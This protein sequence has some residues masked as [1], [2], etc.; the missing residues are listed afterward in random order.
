[1][2][3]DGVVLGVA[4]VTTTIVEGE[5]VVVK[6]ALVNVVLVLDDKLEE[7]VGVELAEA[8]EAVV[9]EVPGLVEV[10]LPDVE[11]A[12][13]AGDETAVDGSLSL[14]IPQGIA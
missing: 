11:L 7:T 14:P 2:F 1:M 4:S 9:V 10:G 12:G 8:A 3:A 13:G 6:P 5:G